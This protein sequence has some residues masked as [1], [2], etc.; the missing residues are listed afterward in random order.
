[1]QTIETT[2]QHAYERFEENRRFEEMTDIAERLGYPIDTT[3]GYE[4][5]DDAVYAL[6]DTVE[7][8]FHNQT[9][10]AFITGEQQYNGDQSFQRERLR[11]EHEEALLVDQLAAGGL[12]G[13]VLVKYSKVPDAIV[14]GRTGINGYR[15]D[16]L[17]SFVRIYYRTESGVAC[18]LFTLDHNHPEGVAQVGALL[19]IDTTLP[20]E[21]V[22]ADSSLL[23]VPGNL[24]TFT[25]QLVERVKSSYDQAV[26]DDSG[27]RT[28]AGSHY[29]G[30]QD[31]MRAIA[32]QSHLVTQHMAAIGALMGLG[33]DDDLEQERKKTAAAIKLATEGHVIGSS[34]DAAVSQELHVGNY[35]R[36]C[37]TS[38]GMNQAARSQENVWAFGECQVCFAKTMVGS[39]MVCSACAAADDRGEDLL[40]LRD[41]NLRRRKLSAQLGKLTTTK[42]NVLKAGPK[43]IELIR[44]RYG[45]YA[46]LRRQV[47]IGGTRHTVH[48]RRTGQ[49]LT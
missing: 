11:L 39:C 22:L 42:E 1:M 21:A 7:R 17:R 14:E 40:V 27:R 45:Q 6:S 36:D 46:E 48:D 9:F 47:V 29:E 19:G 44:Q 25:D 18:R 30:H 15:R 33:R 28:Y 2:R 5:R 38:N 37:P 8:P 49:L 4:L 35:E 12:A 20:S 3:I 23:S 13:N 26:F 10:L 31:A 41:R 43:K 32:A 24:E 16:L 34:G